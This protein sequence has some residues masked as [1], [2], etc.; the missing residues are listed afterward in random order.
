[1]TG[2]SLATFAI[3][4]T[5]HYPFLPIWFGRYTLFLLCGYALLGR[6]FAYLGV[7][8]V[9]VGEI[10]LVLA[11]LAIL[12]G[13]PRG[14][15]RSPVTWLLVMFMLW[16]AA[17][18]FPYLG[19]YGLDSL[20]DGVLWGYAIYSLAV[21]ATLLRLD[22]IEK[23]IELYARVIPVFLLLI[24]IVMAIYLFGQS[25]I[26]RWPW[27]PGSGVGIIHVKPGDLAVHYSGLFAFLMLE[28][29]GRAFQLIW[30]LLWLLGVAP[31]V[32]LTRAGI[33]T[34]ACT[35]SL[36]A[37]LRP[38]FKYFYIAACVGIC[39]TALYLA[40]LELSVGYTVRTISVD[41]LVS[42]I[43]SILF[44]ADRPEFGLEAT[45]HWRELWWGKIVDYTVHGDYF[46]TGKGFG[47]NL[48]D[49]DGFQVDPDHTL[50]SPHNAHMT[51]LARAGVPGLVLWIA[52]QGTFAVQ[53]LINFIVDQ[54]MGR[55]R[56]ATIEIWTFIYW[57]AFQ[58]NGS[59][60]VFLEG[61]QGGIWFWS[62]FGFGLALIVA[63]SE[64]TTVQGRSFQPRSS[65]DH[66][67][68]QADRVS[69]S[70]GPPRFIWRGAPGRPGRDRGRAGRSR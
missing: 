1:M 34:I 60:D 12:P 36:V 30:L 69:A 29:S 56:L 55:R 37:L 57:L 24:P 22:A 6:G 20:R 2:S 51:I 65:S 40:G 32:M 18:T 59:F 58:I 28:L 26:P 47:I 44:S 35:A 39:V 11:V 23:M 67:S 16:G 9:F 27:G 45:K 46:W 19:E 53:L 48:A 70:R 5:R 8:P 10:G 52:M 25:W 15:L 66:G 61:P 50:R 54:R 31:V 49:A 64:I 62:L 7:P 21:A 42:N 63:R 33:M 38:S 13:V 17:C 68:S 4:R 14:V 43:Q 3:T 41:Q